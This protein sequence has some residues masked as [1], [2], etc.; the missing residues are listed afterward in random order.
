M[1][2]ATLAIQEFYMKETARAVF[3]AV[4]VSYKTPHVPMKAFFCPAFSLLYRCVS[5]HG[6][7]LLA[8]PRVSA[9]CVCVCVWC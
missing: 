1:T 2:D 8:A 3:L 6:G 7:A 5:C 9:P 4:D